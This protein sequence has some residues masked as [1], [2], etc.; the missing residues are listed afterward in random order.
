VTG[1][2][3]TRSDGRQ[4][5]MSED[6]ELT[7]EEKAAFDEL[8]REASP[9]AFLEERIVRALREDGILRSASGSLTPALHGESHRRLVRPWVVAAASMAASVMLFG[10]GVAVGQWMGTRSTE[11]ILL[12]ARQQDNTLVAQRVQEAGSAYVQA[13][14]ALAALRDSPAAGA[15][16]RKTV[17]SARVVSEIQQGGEAA[18]GALYAAALELARLAPDDPDVARILEM[19]EDRRFASVSGSGAT[20]SMWY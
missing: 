13:L 1:D 7:P 2:R 9:S 20:R 19:L 4:T 18:V 12:A 15:R 6:I 17:P 14:A 5:G 16:G 11:R 3:N 8:R 10:S